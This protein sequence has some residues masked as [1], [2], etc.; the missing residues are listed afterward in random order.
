M[1][2]E[3]EFEKVS[4]RLQE[5]LRGLQYGSVTLIVQDGK[6]IQLEKSEKVRMK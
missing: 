5:L 6:V 2:N 4:Q 1:T 3:Q